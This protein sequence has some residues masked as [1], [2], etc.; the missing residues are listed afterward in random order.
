[1]HLLIACCNK[2][3]KRVKF[4]RFKSVQ[5]ISRYLQNEDYFVGSNLCLNVITLL[6]TSTDN[7]LFKNVFAEW[8]DLD[9]SFGTMNWLIDDDDDDDDENVLQIITIFFSIFAWQKSSWYFDSSLSSNFE[10]KENLVSFPTK[11]ERIFSFFT[12]GGKI[13][14]IF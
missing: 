8:S 6:S 2:S 10:K 5:T 4:F 12:F 13:E 11:L 3:S 14:M 1:M 9:L 7:R